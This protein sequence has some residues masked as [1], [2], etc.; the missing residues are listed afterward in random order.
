M[1]DDSKWENKK[2]ENY[3]FL[4]N[5][6]RRDETVDYIEYYELVVNTK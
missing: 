4:A 1:E 6:L 5:L 2:N 3:N